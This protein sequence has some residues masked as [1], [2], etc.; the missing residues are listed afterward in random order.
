MYLEH[1]FAVVKIFELFGHGQLIFSDSDFIVTDKEL[2][3][4]F[5]NFDYFCK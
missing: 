2:T 1:V 3:K 5:E 4:Q